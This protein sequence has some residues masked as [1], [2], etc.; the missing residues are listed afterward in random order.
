MTP[1]SYP[2]DGNR[3]APVLDRRQT[4]F[5]LAALIAAPALSACSGGVAADAA[6]FEQ[7]VLVLADL[8][9]PETETPGAGTS[10][11]TAFIV[12]AADAK[13]LQATAESLAATAMELRRRSPSQFLSLSRPRQHEIL[14]QLDADVYAGKANGTGWGQLKTLILAAYYTSEVGASNELVYELVPGRY[15]ADIPLSARPVPLSNDWT[16]V[17][18]HKKAPD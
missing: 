9:L 6:D 13:L 3:A 11:T 16:A 12:K 7:L 18:M 17:A 5:A 14:A 8:T 15:D 4:L 10:D 1:D 2:V